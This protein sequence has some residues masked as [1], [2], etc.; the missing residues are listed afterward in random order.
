MLLLILRGPRHVAIVKWLNTARTTGENKGL[1][2]FAT[3]VLLHFG[4]RKG[5]QPH[6]VYWEG[7]VEVPTWHHREQQ[8][9]AARQRWTSNKLPAQQES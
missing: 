1:R 2:G 8:G 4:G 7:R 3:A 5:L 6:Q 9:G